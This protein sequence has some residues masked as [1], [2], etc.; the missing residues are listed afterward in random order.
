MLGDT[1]GVSSTPGILPLISGILAH[2]FLARLGPRTPKVNRAS[3][4]EDDFSYFA[5]M[6]NGGLEEEFSTLAYYTR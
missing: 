1:P 4:S 2:V 5:N 3:I 6:N